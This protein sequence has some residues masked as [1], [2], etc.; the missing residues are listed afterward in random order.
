MHSYAVLEKLHHIS[1]FWPAPPASLLATLCV[2]SEVT[3]V[4]DHDTVP[5]DSSG[6]FSKSEPCSLLFATQHRDLSGLC[7]P[8]SCCFES[9]DYR[10]TTELQPCLLHQLGCN[11]S[12]AVT[13]LMS[14]DAGDAVL[15][16]FACFCWPAWLW[17]V[18]ECAV[19]AVPVSPSLD[20]VVIFA[21]F[22]GNLPVRPVWILLFQD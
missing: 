9:S 16:V 17:L 7:V 21:N 11:A 14:W 6:C 18:C 13:G 22:A 10:T 15:C 4:R 19:L 12:S 5:R 20:K 1:V 2:Q 8:E 3:A